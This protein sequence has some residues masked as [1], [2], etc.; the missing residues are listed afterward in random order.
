ME[1]SLVM[2]LPLPVVPDS[3]SHPCIARV[4]RLL[5]IVHPSHSAHRASILLP[6]L[7]FMPPPETKTKAAG[8]YRWMNFNAF[9]QDDAICVI[10]VVS[11]LKFL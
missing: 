8:S 2:H 3:P 7:S 10:Q 6:Q 5:P 11:C 1:M 9:K 4:C